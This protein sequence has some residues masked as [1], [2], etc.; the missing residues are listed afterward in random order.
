MIYNLKFKNKNNMTPLLASIKNKKYKLVEYILNFK[1]DLDLYDNLGR[2]ALFHACQNNFFEIAELL[3]KKGAN[4]NISNINNQSPLFWS[5][6]NNNLELVKLLVDS[7]S[8]VENI[9]NKN[10]S[11]LYIATEKG[12][13]E[14]IDIIISYKP[15]LPK[16]FSNKSP[17]EIVTYIRNFYKPT[18][19]KSLSS[20]SLEGYGEGGGGGGGGGG[21]ACYPFKKKLEKEPKKFLRFENEQVN[22]FTTYLNFEDNLKYISEWGY[23]LPEPDSDL[24]EAD[25]AKL[26]HGDILMNQYGDDVD[27]QWIMSQPYFAHYNVIKINSKGEKF[28]SGTE[29]PLG[30]ISQLSGGMNSV[31][32]AI[33]TNITSHIENPITFYNK[34]ALQIASEFGWRGKEAMRDCRNADDAEIL[35][36]LDNVNH[37]NVIYKWSSIENIDQ[38]IGFYWDG[39]DLV[40]E[41]DEENPIDSIQS[42]TLTEK[43][44]DVHGNIF[45][46]KKPPQLIK[47]V[48]PSQGGGGGS[49]GE[50]LLTLS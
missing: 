18:L 19:M 4:V 16:F 37:Y 21:G 22:I 34:L 47:G 24:F 11:I 32:F 25:F 6:L 38:Y 44:E 45:V 29:T 43:D 31:R 2:T 15:K 36:E 42:R 5:I 1:P 33:F 3:I 26:K 40:V 27:V 10:Q 7:G 35:I 8:D 17:P 39:H 12:N 20:S 28:A 30:D 49:G 41:Q 46:E 48:T 50:T 13:K 9:D 23:K 14:I